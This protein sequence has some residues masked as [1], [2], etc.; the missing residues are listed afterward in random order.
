MHVQRKYGAWRFCVDYRKLNNVTHKDVFPLLRI[1]DCLTSLGR[2]W[3]I[4]DSA[5]EKR[6]FTTPFDFF[7]F[8]KMPFRLCY[9]P[10][11]FQG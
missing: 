10:V 2:Y 8:E 3:Q 7:E 1:K 9:A 4:E 6:V 5:R 11:T